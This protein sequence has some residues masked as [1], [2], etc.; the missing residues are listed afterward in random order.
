MPKSAIFRCDASPTMGGGHVQRCLVLADVLASAGWNCRFACS[1]ESTDIVPGLAAGPHG[2]IVL[3]EPDFRDGT[4]LREVV[5]DG[6][7]LL[8]VDHYGLG[9]AYES[10]LRGWTASIMAIDDLAD[11]SHDCDILLDQTPDASAG[12]YAGLVPERC[13]KLL[14]GEYALLRPQFERA[15]WANGDTLVRHEARRV[16][17]GFGA[18]D[19]KNLSAASVAAAG[20]AS[21]A[22]KSRVIVGRAARGLPQLRKL[23]ADGACELAIDVGDMA[24]AMLAADFAI[25]AG[26]T[27]SLER[28]CMGLPTLLVVTADNQKTVAEALQ[29]RHA[30]RIVASYPEVSDAAIEAGVR[31]LIADGDSLREMSRA[32]LTVCDGLGARRALHAIAAPQTADGGAVRLRPAGADDS[33]AIFGWQQHPQTRRFFRHPEAPSRAEHAQWFADK[34]RD[35]GCALNIITHNDTP[36]GLLR[37][38][39]TERTDRALEVSIL[40]APT[41]YRLGLGRQALALAEAIWAHTPQ[42]AEVH[43]ENAASHGLFRKAGFTLVGGLYMKSPTPDAE[44]EVRAIAR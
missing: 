5:P 34:L 43:S 33:E 35:P 13:L 1:P 42:V 3:E 40:I 17:I 28:C 39:R 23:A 4:R 20:R 30:A 12:R 2:L 44:N 18:V 15:R 25:G 10:S 8:V 21:P 24:A 32:A 22:L 37:L 27:S 38:D 31:S 29:T 26:G 16:L 7:D 11:R 19:G 6:C 36:A 14:G 9:A 41:H